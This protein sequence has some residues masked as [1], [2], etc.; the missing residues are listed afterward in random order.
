MNTERGECWTLGTE[1]EWAPFSSQPEDRTVVGSV[2][3]DGDDV[4][5]P[6]TVDQIRA[7]ADSLA[8]HAVK[9]RAFA[10]RLVETQAEERAARFWRT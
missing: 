4:P 6:M 3:L 9:L 7:L 1:I 5:V 10:D 2:Y 8:G